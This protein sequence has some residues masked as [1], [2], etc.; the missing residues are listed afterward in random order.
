MIEFAPGQ[1]VMLNEEGDALYVTIHVRNYPK[2]GKVYIIRDTIFTSF[3]KEQI[4]LFKC[5]TAAA[6]ARFFKHVG[7]PW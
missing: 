3:T 5:G 7:G 4:L 6:F 1:E 2:P